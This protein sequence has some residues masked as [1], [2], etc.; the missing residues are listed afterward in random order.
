MLK[1]LKMIG[2]A[3]VIA[4]MPL[5]ANALTV[6]SDG[7]SYTL[8]APGAAP[9]LGNIDAVGGGGTFTSTFTATP[10]AFGEMRLS[11]IPDFLALF[12]GL[13]AEWQTVGGAVLAAIDPIL[14]GSS[15]LLTTF[16]VANST[17]NLVFTWTG[18][19]DTSGQVNGPVGFDFAVSPVP[20]PA[21]GFLLIGA[22]GGL[23]LMRR[24]RKTA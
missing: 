7:G 17:Q 22:L 12:T 15:K 18:S 1:K 5:S 21:A 11:V 16:D 3:L 8:D 19:V 23:G 24:R 2:V 10:I 4:A 9:F 13:K 20:V 14:A 6:L